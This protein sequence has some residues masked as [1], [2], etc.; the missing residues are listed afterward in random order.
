L[1]HDIRAA[2]ATIILLASVLEAATPDEHEHAHEHAHALLGIVECA[3]TIVGLA[4]DDTT[5]RLV[6][7]V[8]VASVVRSSVERARLAFPVTLELVDDTASAHVAASPLDI[9]RVLDNLL[10]NACRAADRGSVSVHVSEDL[11]DV[12]I[13][14]VDDGPGIDSAQAVGGLGLS[15]V[16]ALVERLGGRCTVA[17]ID[18]HGGTRAVVELP[19]ADATTP[20]LDT[21]GSPPP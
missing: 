18:E 7:P 6:E 11:D 17:R 4:A 2:A 1:Q 14:I 3:R 19:R 13:E 9:T 21:H 16:A 5:I 20:N 8:A 10:A 12:V 15:I